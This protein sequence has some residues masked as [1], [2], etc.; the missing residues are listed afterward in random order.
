ML[1]TA[2]PKETNNAELKIKQYENYIDNEKRIYIANEIV[3]Q[4]IKSSIGLI[5]QLSQYY[6][7]YIKSMKKEIEQYEQQN[8]N[9]QKQYKHKKENNENNE[10]NKINSLTI[11][12]I[13]MYEG[14]IAS[15]YWSSLSKILNELS[16][17]F[18]FETRKNLSYSWNMNASDEVNALLNYGYAILESIITLIL[19]KFRHMFYLD[20]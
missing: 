2:T 7:I 15:S 20:A 16:P 8:E 14:R 4:K 9:K 19:Q 13:M 3:K 5:K 17:D 1:Y 12:D 18:H 10:K 6:D 11:N